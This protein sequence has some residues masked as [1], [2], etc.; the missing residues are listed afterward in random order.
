MIMTFAVELT[1]ENVADIIA[2]AAKWNLNVDHLTDS[3]ELAIEDGVK[4]YGILSINR[5]FRHA[6]FCELEGADFDA[7]WYFCNGFTHGR[8][9]RQVKFV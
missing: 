9:Y 2:D 1:T 4:L 6:T 3:V 8:H 5:K 7:V